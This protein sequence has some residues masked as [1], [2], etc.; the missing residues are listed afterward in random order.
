[1]SS[2]DATYYHPYLTTGIAADRCLARRTDDDTAQDRRWKPIV[3]RAYQCSNKPVS[4]T[5]LC[6]TCNR[7]KTAYDT[8]HSVE[9][10]NWH[11]VVSDPD[12]LPADSHIHGSAWFRAKAKWMGTV[13]PKTAKQDGRLEVAPRVPAKELSR[14]ARGECDLDLE[15]LSA[16]NQ[17]GRVELRVILTQICDVKIPDY[18][19]RADL[20]KRIR[21]YRPVAVAVS[22]PEPQTESK[23]KSTMAT[24]L[25]VLKAKNA[26]IAALEAQVA[27]LTASLAAKDAKL[28]A[29]R[30]AMGV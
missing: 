1:M 10:S 14:F 20:I 17:I 25:R 11:G 27:E 15:T 3:N 12:S 4:G 29:I 26:Q 19:T 9:R 21:R 18:L 8:T 28:D 6:E 23:P 5:D 22:D 16:K 24:A 2:P 13:K 7:H 30:A